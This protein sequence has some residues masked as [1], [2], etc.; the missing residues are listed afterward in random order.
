MQLSRLDLHRNGL[1][2]SKE[3]KNS[4]NDEQ[5]QYFYQ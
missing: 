5:R 2:V 3:K 4:L 1:I